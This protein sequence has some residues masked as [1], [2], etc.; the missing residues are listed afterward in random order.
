M[1]L[2]PTIIFYLLLILIGIIIGR[3]APFT[4]NAVRQWYY[5][6]RGIDYFV[7]HLIDNG[8]LINT[9][10]VEATERKYNYDGSDYVLFNKEGSSKYVPYLNFKGLKV[11][12][13]NK[14]NINPLKITENT[15]E[16]SS[17]DPE[18]FASLIRN[19]DIRDLTRDTTED[20]I[21]GIKRYVLIAMI[22]IAGVVS[23]V[24]WFL[25]SNSGG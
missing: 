2:N 1:I 8:S 25:L 9:K 7:C 24:L 15:I 12:F 17:N 20:L 11:V 3:K 10:T 4:R 18:I 16:P 22:V 6:R 21:S 14:N 5:N 23:A 19:K 13:H